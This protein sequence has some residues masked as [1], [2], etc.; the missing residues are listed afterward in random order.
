MADRSQRAL[1]PLYELTDSVS[2]GHWTDKLA[3]VSKMHNY[4][5]IDALEGGSIR[6]PCA[7]TAGT[8]S[9]TLRYINTVASHGVII[10]PLARTGKMCFRK[11]RTLYVGWEGF[12][13]QQV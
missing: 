6:R 3:W 8:S 10:T 9:H 2:Y 11:C 4:L 5:H 12:V 1:W 7:S 13:K